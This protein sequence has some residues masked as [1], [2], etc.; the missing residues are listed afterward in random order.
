MERNQTNQ[1]FNAVN[2]DDVDNQLVLA[3]N[4]SFLSDTE[5]N[6]LPNTEPQEEETGY[7]GKKFLESMYRGGKQA[8]QDTGEIFGEKLE[9]GEGIG[10]TSLLN[11]PGDLTLRTFDREQKERT[12]HLKQITN[13]RYTPNVN[14]IE[15][16]VGSNFDLQLSLGFADN[17]E[18]YINGLKN[19]LSKKP[20]GEDRIID[21]LEDERED[22]PWYMPKY[23]IS[24]EKDDGSM[25][26]YSNPHQSVT[27]F[28]ARA[29]GQLGFD[30][31]AGTV[32]VGTA[33][34]MGMTA[35]KLTAGLGAIPGL[36]VAA[37]AA[38][39]FIG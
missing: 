25:T 36:G 10:I 16:Y 35:A 6:Q 38:A 23:Y 32:E 37:L 3:G 7:F 21:V 34:T 2:T 12:N 26:N 27:D 19:Q 15:D 1:L 11:L 8:I 24:V 29:G 20:D 31:A 18:E 9:R 28:V 13:N 17:R 30:I 14:T 33:A 4:N 39:P 22:K 5:M